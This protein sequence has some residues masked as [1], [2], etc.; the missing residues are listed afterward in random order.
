MQGNAPFRGRKDRAHEDCVV[1]LCKTPA[2]KGAVLAEGLFA[3]DEGAK[4]HH[5]LVVL[6]G[7]SQ[8]KKALSQFC[9]A[10]S[11]FFGAYGQ[12]KIAEAA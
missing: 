2:C 10:G 5:G 4:F 1:F 12:I 7:T 8:G 11:A 3:T 9:Q 6:T